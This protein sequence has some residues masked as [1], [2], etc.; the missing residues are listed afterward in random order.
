M[1]RMAAVARSIASLRSAYPRA[2]VVRASA[3]SWLGQRGVSGIAVEVPG[4]TQHS[5]DD[6]SV[7]V[8]MVNYAGERT[9]M[10]GRVGQTLTEVAADNEYPFLDAACG[11]GGGKFAIEHNAEWTEDQ[12][13]EGAFC[14][15][16]HVVLPL[17]EASNATPALKDE[18]QRLEDHTDP[19]GITRSSRLGCQV[20][21]SKAMDG[22]VVHVPDSGFTDI[23]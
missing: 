8:V 21:L 23:P 7:R 4:V 14:S 3:R 13:G 10:T 15:Q 22:M 11:G 2:S 5:V 12:Y 20:T 17:E 18:L 6:T 9:V 1:A 16:C 19:D